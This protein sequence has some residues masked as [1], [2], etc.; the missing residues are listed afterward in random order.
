MDS[1]VLAE[2]MG[3]SPNVDYSKMVGP[4]NEA[5]IAADVTNA[6]RAAM[7]IAQ[8]GHESAG[9]RWMEEI[10]S[11]AAY[12]G[13]ADL[14]NTQPGDGPRFKGRGPIQL[15]GRNNYR[16]FTKWAQ[17]QGHTTINFE[18]EPHRVAEPKWGFLAAAYFWGTRPALNRYSDQ[19]DLL[20]ASAIINGWY[21]DGTGKPRKANG[22]NDRQSRFNR[23]LTMGDRILPKGAPVTDPSKAIIRKVEYDRAEVHQDTIYNCGPASAQTVIK[24]SNGGFHTEVQLGRELRTHTGGTDYIG[25]FIPVLN[26]YLPEG[27]Y[28]S[29]EMPNDPPTAGQRDELWE[30]L[31]NSID[32]G[33]GVVANIVAPPSNYPRA[34]F[35]STQNLQYTGGVVYHYVAVMSYAIEENGQ[36]HVWFADSGFAPYGSWITFEQLSTLIP[37]K[38]YAY[39]TAAPKDVEAPAPTPAP[40]KPE[41]PREDPRDLTLE[42]LK[43]AIA[44]IREQITGS[45]FPGRY[46]GWK[47]LGVDQNGKPLTLVD[48]IASIHKKVSDN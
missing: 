34:S 32:A 31:K 29:V 43:V 47:Q 42:E 38:G 48:A 15:T 45:R 37:P 35:T 23:A 24:A 41:T 6:N 11:G 14:G 25:L 20:R 44:D 40:E 27:K 26:K 13:R 33:Y 12:N 9:L 21:D 16:A 28:R 7:W 5:M 19:R 36:R 1:N 39:S 18:A 22:W 17:E 10:A 8:I 30:N 46:D 3:R 4:I 2:A